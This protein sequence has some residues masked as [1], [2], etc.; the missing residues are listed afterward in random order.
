MCKNDRKWG[1]SGGIGGEPFDCVPFHAHTYYAIGCNTGATT[2]ESSALQPAQMMELRSLRRFSVFSLP[3]AFRVLSE[4]LS[5]NHI[6]K[7]LLPLNS[8]TPSSERPMYVSGLA[9]HRSVGPLPF[10]G[11]GVL[12]RSPLHVGFQCASLYWSSEEA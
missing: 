7:E 10:S 5:T 12:G 6:R 9:K 8:C 3:P 2:G 4:D 1:Q 11:S